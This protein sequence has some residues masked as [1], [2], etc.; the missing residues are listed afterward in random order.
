MD[1]NAIGQTIIE[2][3][4]EL[5]SGVS[6][7][8][9]EDLKKATKPDDTYNKMVAFLD[10]GIAI[11]LAESGGNPNAK[12]GNAQ[13]LWQIM[14]SVHAAEISAAHKYDGMGSKSI[15]D[16]DFNTIVASL[17]WKAAGRS[18]GPWD[19]D[20]GNRPKFRGHGE[21][22]LN[23]YINNPNLHADPQGNPDPSL[24]D[25]IKKSLSDMANGVTPWGN[26]GDVFSFIK[27]SGI[28]VGVF[29]LAL[30]M[31][32]I[33]IIAVIGSNKGVCKAVAKVPI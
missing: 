6:Y 17:V 32:V 28:V 13:G 15:Y 7:K 16:P 10:E 20:L 1:A 12:N 25:N 8:W 26:I 24:S 4:V 2:R 33:G 31:I 18:W 11:V 23:A 30:I 14:T 19:A 5:P 29:L 21:A 9:A 3:W 27:Q 22:A